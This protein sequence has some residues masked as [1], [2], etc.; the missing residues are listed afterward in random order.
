MSEQAVDDQRAA[1]V[2]LK[3]FVDVPTLTMIRRRA[4]RSA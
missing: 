3:V 4:A 1:A 2:E